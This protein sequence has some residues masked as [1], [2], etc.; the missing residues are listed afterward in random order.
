M[1]FEMIVKI[2]AQKLRVDA[3]KPDGLYFRGILNIEGSSLNDQ[4]KT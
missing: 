1:S 3:R 4:V 2:L